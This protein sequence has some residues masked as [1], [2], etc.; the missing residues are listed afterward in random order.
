[1]LVILPGFQVR[2][3]ELSTDLQDYTEQEAR[4]RYVYIQN[5]CLYC[6]SQQPR[7]FGQTPADLAKGWG[8]APTPADYAFDKPHLLGT[9]RTGPDLLNVGARL[10][11]EEWHLTHLY[12]P[13]AIF[14][15]SIMPSYPYLFEVKEK[16]EANDVVVKLPKD[17]APQDGK[18]VVARQDALD[19]VVYLQSLDRT[20]PTSES[21]FHLRDQGYDGHLKTDSEE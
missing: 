12:Q 1:M 19:L 13:R 2:T 6:H 11:S 20:Y 8:R 3:L 7:S 17:F 10:P 16:A 4:G 5:G 15:W 14:D 9:M 21:E 18:V